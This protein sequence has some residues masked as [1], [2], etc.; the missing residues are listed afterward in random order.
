MRGASTRSVFSSLFIF[1]FTFLRGGF[2]TRLDGPARQRKLRRVRSPFR[3]ASR[4]KPHG[5]NFLGTPCFF[6]KRCLFRSEGPETRSTTDIL[7][8]SECGIDFLHRMLESFPE[9][10]LCQSTFVAD[11]IYV[12]YLCQIA[13]VRMR[14]CVSVCRYLLVLEKGCERDSSSSTERRRELELGELESACMRV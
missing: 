5:S 7:R 11:M 9:A 10:E 13:F 2:S 8:Q 4:L 12:R 1:F 14:V 6:R 3:H